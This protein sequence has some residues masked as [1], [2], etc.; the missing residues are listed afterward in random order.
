MKHLALALA[1]A[2]LTAAS[3]AQSQSLEGIAVRV[4]DGD[5]FAFSALRIR[6]CGIEAP[7]RGEQGYWQA[8]QALESLIKGKF[9]RCLPV[10]AGSVCDSRSKIFNRNRVVAQC[11]VDG[12]DIAASMVQSGNACDWMKFSGGAY[13]GGCQ[14]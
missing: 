2:I 1:W 7:D 9:V 10:G 12:T 6:I 11:F 13:P 4:I 5:T 14:K 3:A 8:A